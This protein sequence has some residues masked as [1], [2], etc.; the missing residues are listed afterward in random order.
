MDASHIPAGRRHERG[1]TLLEL[2]VAMTV[3]GLIGL[4]IFGV[5]VLGAR[6]AGSGERITEQARRYRIANEIITRQVAAA[7]AIQLPKQDDGG[8]GDDDSG[9][10]AEP[11]FHGD[12]ETVEFVTT[13]PQRPDASGM[14]IVNY[15]LEDGML[16]MSEKPVFSAYGTGKKLDRKDRNDS[17]VT[18]LLYDIDSLTFSYQRESDA[19]EWLDKWDAVDD[20]KLPACV[21]IDVKPSAVGGPDFYHELPVMVGVYG[22]ITDQDS[23]FMSRRTRLRG[24][25]PED[26]PAPARPPR[27]Q[28]AQDD[29]TDS[30][31]ATVPDDNSDE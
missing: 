21:R 5:L 15:W 26:S 28:P 22:Q 1:F 10:T 25:D 16:K 2:I 4:G 29:N 19:D 8:L 13:A 20:E 3:F 11:F 23:D 30:P 17:V 12:V 31:G 24:S 14:A 7:E 6:S 18:T 9:S 27:P